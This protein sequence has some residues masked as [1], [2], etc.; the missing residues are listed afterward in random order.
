MT[1]ELNCFQKYLLGR[2]LVIPHMPP[3]HANSL[4]NFPVMQDSVSFRKEEILDLILKW[5][6]SH[7]VTPDRIP[8]TFIIKVAHIIAGHL[9]ILAS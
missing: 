3:S 1:E 6:R 7:Y 8:P 4:P 2:S 5:P 9:A